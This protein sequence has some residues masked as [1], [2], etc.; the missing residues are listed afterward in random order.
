[1][2]MPTPEQQREY[3]RQWV[4]DRRREWIEANG[5][6]VKCGST[7]NLEVDHIDPVQK[8][9]P[10]AT[11]WSWTEARRLAELAKCQVLCRSCHDEKS[12]EDGYPRTAVHGTRRRYDRG[13]RCDLCREARRL[14]AIQQRASKKARQA[15]GAQ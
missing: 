11:I 13:C 6:C 14:N 9:A 15:T 1:M 2:P 10:V 4:A 7:E 12:T 5:P 8:S 3:Q